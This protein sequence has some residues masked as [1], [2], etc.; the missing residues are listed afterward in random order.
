LEKV[1]ALRTFF[2]SRPGV[3]FRAEAAADEEGACGFSKE[4]RAFLAINAGNRRFFV[5]ANIEFSAI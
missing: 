2:R 3:P 5:R 4:T 1:N